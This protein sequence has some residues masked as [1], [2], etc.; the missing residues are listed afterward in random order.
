MNV[1]NAVLEPTAT[2]EVKQAKC[3]LF[4]EMCSV[5]DDPVKMCGL[6]R[7][8]DDGLLGA[9][10]CQLVRMKMT[11]DKCTKRSQSKCKEQDGCS[12]SWKY[13]KSHPERYEKALESSRVWKAKK[14]S[15]DKG[16]ASDACV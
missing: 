6:L 9:L 12:L 16:D 3:R 1:N 4:D 13:L 15:L 14:R 2:S 11:K 5:V 7:V 8:A 10:V